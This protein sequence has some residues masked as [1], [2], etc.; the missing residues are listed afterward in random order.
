MTE[1][2]WGC[3][4]T[5][6]ESSPLARK[7]SLNFMIQLLCGSCPTSLYISPASFCD[8]F[9]LPIGKMYQLAHT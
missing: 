6:V 5:S 8:N 1:I 9:H 3:V 7:C 4:G 2:V